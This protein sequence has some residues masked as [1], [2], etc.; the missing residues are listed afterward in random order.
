M[1]LRIIFVF[2]ASTPQTPT[3]ETIPNNLNFSL[4]RFTGFLVL[5]FGKKTNPPSHCVD[6]SCLLNPIHFH[7]MSKHHVP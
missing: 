4:M 2:L 6:I 3:P 7:W 1:N 5:F